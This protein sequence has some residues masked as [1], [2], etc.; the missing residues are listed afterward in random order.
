MTVE[1]EARQLAELLAK[2]AELADRVEALE[3]RVK[4]D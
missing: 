3:T 4:N 2:I 1:L